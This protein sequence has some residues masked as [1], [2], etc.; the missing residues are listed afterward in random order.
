MHC[1]N[2][3]GFLRVDLNSRVSV[4]WYFR[5]HF[6]TLNFDIFCLFHYLDEGEEVEQIHKK[7]FRKWINFKLAMVSLARF[8]IG[9]VNIMKDDRR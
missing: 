7:I 6:N 1:S 9:R 2:L 5:L 3:T 8:E 4:R